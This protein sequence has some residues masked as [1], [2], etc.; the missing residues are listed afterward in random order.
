MKFAAK[1]DYTYALKIKYNNK[2]IHE[3][4]NIKFMGIILDNTIIMEKSY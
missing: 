1:Q 4:N 3:A 2:N